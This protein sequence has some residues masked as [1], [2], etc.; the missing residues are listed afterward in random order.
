MYQVK[1]RL[2]N[3]ELFGS[4]LWN[5]SH[6][7]LLIQAAYYNHPTN[8][9]FHSLVDRL[10]SSLNW[11]ISSSLAPIHWLYQASTIPSS[12]ALQ[13]SPVKSRR[14]FFV[15]K[16]IYRLS[17]QALVERPKR[18][19]NVQS[20]NRT[21]FGKFTHLPIC[22]VHWVNSSFLSI[23]CFLIGAWKAF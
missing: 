2:K 5:S 6:L 22:L 8:F 4:A 11:G 21:R 13:A 17:S 1:T 15:W 20:L 18:C 3:Q 19:Y 7:H 14:L 9:F 16:P 10:T 23:I 12:A